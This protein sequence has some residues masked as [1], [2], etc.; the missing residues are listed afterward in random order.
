MNHKFRKKRWKVTF[1]KLNKIY[2]LCNY[3]TKEITI[4]KSLDGDLRLD[5][6][7]HECLHACY[8]DLDDE[9]IDETATDITKLLSRLGYGLI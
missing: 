3:D 4:R 5:T 2:G 7:I 8:P 6:I 1:G 9:C